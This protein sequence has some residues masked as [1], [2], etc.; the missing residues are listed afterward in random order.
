MYFIGPIGCSEENNYFDF[1]ESKD[2]WEFIGDKRYQSN[3]D[4]VSLKCLAEHLY[5]V[6]MM[7]EDIY[8]DLCD[9]LCIVRLFAR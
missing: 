2:Y 8:S 9:L 4:P 6:K 1:N 3:L 5:C 7:F